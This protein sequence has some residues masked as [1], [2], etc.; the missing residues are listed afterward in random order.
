[1]TSRLKPCFQEVYNTLTPKGYGLECRGLV[2][3]KGK[4]RMLTYYLLHGPRQK[5]SNNESVA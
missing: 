5:E 1:M 2:T 3:V 4:G